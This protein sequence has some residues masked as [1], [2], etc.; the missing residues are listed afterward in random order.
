MVRLADAGT[1]HLD[2]PPGVIDPR[3]SP[4]GSHVAYVADGALHVQDVATGTDDV[5]AAPDGPDVTWGLAEFIAAEEMDRMCGYWWSPDG[6]GP[7]WRSGPTS[8]TSSAGTSATR[9]TPRQSRR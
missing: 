1:T 2:T 9:P 6:A 7:S 4:D 3:L 5:L 8:R